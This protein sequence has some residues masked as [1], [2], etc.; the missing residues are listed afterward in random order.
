MAKLASLY[1]S[2]FRLLGYSTATIIFALLA[3]ERCHFRD[4]ITHSAIELD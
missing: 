2:V 4:H 3:D 1:G